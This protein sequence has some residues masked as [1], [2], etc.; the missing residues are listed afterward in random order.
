MKRIILPGYFIL[1]SFFSVHSQHFSQDSLLRDLG[2]YADVMVNADLDAHRI[3]AHDKF[4]GILKSFLSSP[5]SCQ[6]P[7]DSIRWISVVK[8]ENFR[9][10]SWQLRISNEEYKYGGFIQ[11][12]DKVVELKDTRPWLNGS[13]RSTYTPAAW[14]GALY[15]KLIP[16]KKDAYV[17]F[18]FNAENSLVNTKVVDILDLSAE[19]PKFGLPVFVGIDDPQ[20]RL[21]LTYADASSV[22]LLFDPELNAIV[23]DHLEQLPGIGPEGQ[24]LAVSDGSQEGWFHKNGKWVYQ[25]KVY[26]VKS[27]VPPMTDERKE[28][29]EDRD[30]LGRP[31]KG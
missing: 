24:M 31:K 14:Y 15:Y 8:N 13:L 28:R 12:P 22:Q 3:K 11:W 4:Y 23:H 17:L 1:I 7:L 21:I 5:A 19:E 16:Y 6:V 18:G 9:I 27:D 20:S 26:D 29:K 25:E 30:I 10:I 2:F